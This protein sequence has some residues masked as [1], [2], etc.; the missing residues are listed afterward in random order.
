[1]TLA[2]LLQQQELSCNSNEDKMEETEKIY[3]VPADS[4]AYTRWPQ[5]LQWIFLGIGGVGIAV[6]FWGLIRYMHWNSL[7]IIGGSNA[8]TDILIVDSSP[9]LPWQWILLICI[10]LL[11][12]FTGIALWLFRRKQISRRNKK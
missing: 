5:I 8:S 9:G 10:S 1:M 11:C 4:R 7:G 12:L 6:V 3:L 2:D